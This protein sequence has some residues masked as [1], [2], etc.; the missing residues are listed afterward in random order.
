MTDARCSS[1]S[2]R[3]RFNVGSPC[4]LYSSW[5][6]KSTRLGA[7][8]MSR[9]N[10]QSAAEWMSRRHQAVLEE[11]ERQKRSSDNQGDIRSLSDV[12]AWSGTTSMPPP[13][14][15][16]LQQLK[17][18][19]QLRG[20]DDVQQFTAQSE[21]PAVFSATNRT[22]RRKARAARAARQL[23]SPSLPAVCQQSASSLPADSSLPAAP[24]AGI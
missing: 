13:N 22:L 5:L 2:E 24:Q 15:D 12:E 20:D 18:A 14:G 11:Y 8:R 9:F 3:Y 10:A 21:V 4:P 17:V 16:F 19:L 6:G 7:A 1:C 23:A